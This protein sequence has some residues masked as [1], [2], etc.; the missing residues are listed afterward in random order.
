M[1]TLSI[2]LF[3]LFLMI[4]C[5]KMEEVHQDYISDGEIIYRAKPTDIVGY[6]GINRAKL[7]WKLV[8]PTFVTKCEIRENDSTLFEVPIEYNDTVNIEYILSDLDE[9]THTFSIYSLNSEGNSSIRS[10]IIVEV[11]GEKYSNTLKTNT[12]LKSVWRRVDDKQKVLIQ[13]SERSSSKIVST[14]IFYLNSAGKE[15]NIQVNPATSVVEIENVANDSYFKLQDLYQPVIN[16]IDTFPAPAQEYPA[17]KLPKEGS[18]T[19]SIIYKT[20]DNTVYGTLTSPA[21]KT[22]RTKIKYGNN[23]I[24]VGPEVSNVTLKNVMP[25]DEILLET[26]LQ[27]TESSFEFSAPTQ[28]FKAT[29]LLFKINME[30]WKVV[31]FSSQQ[32]GEGEAAWAIDNQLST[33]WHTQYSPEAPVYHHFITVDMTYSGTIKAIAVARRNGNNNV[34]SLFSLEVSLDGTSWNL[35]KEFSIDNTID[36]LQLVQLETPV[37]GRYFKVTGKTS[38]TSNTFMCIGEINMFK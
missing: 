2:L 8:C 27:D 30:N 10:D 12:F 21:E 25:N 38:A 3:G 36:G 19:F 14:N 1:K 24:V 33:F 20:D 11:F 17:L 28:S 26:I 13:I 37:S 32:A 35:I 9:K 18:R 16:C 29:D 23:E 15:T 4:S 34:A 5:V 22:L 6:S 7:A 31:A